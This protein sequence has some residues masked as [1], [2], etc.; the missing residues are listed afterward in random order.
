MKPDK[1]F[2]YQCG[3]VCL[4]MVVAILCFKFLPESVANGKI[5]N[6]NIKGGFA[7]F[8]VTYLLLFTTF[9]PLITLPTQVVK[10]VS[11][12]NS[13]LF[14]DKIEMV[15]IGVEPK[16]TQ[17][18][19]DDLI[20]NSTRGIDVFFVYS[21]TWLN[22][23]ISSIRK[24]LS[25]SGAEVNFFLLDPESMATQALQEKFNFSGEPPASLKDKINSS[26]SKIQ[27]IGGNLNGKIRIYLQSF[28]PAYA[29]YRFD[30]RI[31]IVNYKQ[32]PGRTNEIPAFI[33]SC[34]DNK[35]LFE[36][37]IND[38]ESFKGKNFQ[39]TGYS[40]LYWQN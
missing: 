5:Y 3:F 18:F 23:H 36:Y 34:K 27:A 7:G 14:S 20:E 12:K 2:L 28:P 19:W 4:S 31:V 6:F 16:F 35:G 1:A 10:N 38:I 9:K 15:N 32:T 29:A 33:Y 8:I 24:F 13:E 37:H 40:K 30:D 26:I 21:S 22:D 25:K 11:A 17:V 39:G